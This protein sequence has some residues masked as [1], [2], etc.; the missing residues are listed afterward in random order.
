MTRD[1]R[2][3]VQ[4]SSRLSSVLSDSKRGTFQVRIAPQVSS[5]PAI[6]PKLRDAGKCHTSLDPCSSSNELISSRESSATSKVNFR[7]AK[8]KLLLENWNVLL[9]DCKV[10][11]LLPFRLQYILPPFKVSTSKI[12]THSLRPQYWFAY[13]IFSIGLKR[14]SEYSRNN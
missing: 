5:L 14:Q 7:K 1:G 3:R 11:Y 8:E 13:E 10:Y 6:L 4:G 2:K 12:Y 9:S